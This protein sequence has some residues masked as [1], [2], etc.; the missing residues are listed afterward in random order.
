MT[1]VLEMDCMKDLDYTRSHGSENL[2]VL[3]LYAL[4]TGHQSHTSVNPLFV[5]LILLLR[6]R[7]FLSPTSLYV[8]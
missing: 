4:S 5:G 7:A 6:A 8:S 3:H 1:R 2:P